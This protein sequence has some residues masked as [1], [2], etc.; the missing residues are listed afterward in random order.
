MK[1]TAN[2]IDRFLNMNRIRSTAIHG[3]RTQ[4]DRDRALERFRAGAI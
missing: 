3:D 2:E 1:R 4:P